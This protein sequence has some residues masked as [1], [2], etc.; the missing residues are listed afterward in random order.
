MILPVVVWQDMVS[1]REVLPDPVINSPY[2]FE[3]Y[4]IYV[5]IHK[6]LNIYDTPMSFVWCSMPIGRIRFASSLTDASML[7]T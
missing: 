4:L 1:R 5:T 7:I 6:Y 3:Q 2:I